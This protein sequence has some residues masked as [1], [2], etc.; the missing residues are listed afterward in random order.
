M[1]WWV[2]KLYSGGQSRV[3]KA[4]CFPV[5]QRVKGLNMPTNDGQIIIHIVTWVKI[6][7]IY[8][9]IEMFIS[10]LKRQS[11]DIFICLFYLVFYLFHRRQIYELFFKLFSK[12]GYTGSEL[13]SAYFFSTLFLYFSIFFRKISETIAL[14]LK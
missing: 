14:L 10:H 11:P 2:C 1:V 7:M 5:P 3:I 6:L 13:T 4:Q 12:K 9:Y 8:F